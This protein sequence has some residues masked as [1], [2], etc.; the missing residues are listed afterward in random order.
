MEMRPQASGATLV[1]RRDELA[2]TVAMIDRAADGQAGALVISGDAGVGKSALVEHACAHAGPSAVRLAGACLPLSAMTVPFLALRSAVRAVE[3]VLDPPADVWGPADNPSNVPVAFDHWL[4]GLSRDRLVVLVIDD[5]QWADQSTLDVLMYL[6]AGPATRRLAVIITVRSGGSGETHPLQRWLADVRRFPR[7]EQMTLAPLDRVATSEQLTE[8]LGTSPHQTLVEEVFARTRGNAY[9]NRLLV[10]D[11]APDT[12]S[13][14]PDLPADLTS[15]VLRSWWM[16]PAPARDLTRILAAGGVPLTTNDLSS[17]AAHA[18]G[19]QPRLSVLVAIESGI[20]DEGP[21]G[22]LWFRHPMIAEVLEHHLTDDERARWHAAFAVH[23]ETQMKDHP[24]PSLDLLFAAADHHHRAGHVLDAYRWAL[25]AAALAGSS[26]GT[27]EELRLLQ[28]A[29]QLRRTHSFEAQ[30]SE[31]D[32][33]QRMVSAAANTG[34]HRAELHA[35]DQLLVSVDNSSEPLLAAQLLVRRAELRFLTGRDFLSEADVREAVRLSSA[36]DPASWQHACAAAALVRIAMWTDDSD[37]EPLADRALAIARG[38]DHP[39]ALSCALSAKASVDVVHGRHREGLRLASEAVTAAARAR[40]FHAYVAG[41]VWEHNSQASWSPRLRATHLRSRR[42]H[43][44]GLG[45]PHAYSAV[46]SAFEADAWL[47]IG[48]WQSC[49]ERLREALGSDPGAFVDVHARLTSARLAAWQGRVAEAQG[50]LARA[51][52]LFTEGSEFL[53]FS[54]DVSRAAVALAAGDPG[55]AVA[56][57]MAGAA[58]DVP[59]DKCEWLMALAARAL[60]DLS[61]MDRDAGRDPLDQLARLDDLTA[62]FPTVIRDVGE[63]EDLHIVALN[64]LY[65]AEIG[66]A[67]RDPHNGDQWLRARDS[68]HAATLA[69][70]EAYACWRAAESLLAH[71]RHRRT[72]AASV[73]RRGLVLAARLGAEPIADALAALAS[74]ARIEVAA[75]VEVPAVTLAGLP[76]LT[77]RESEILAHVVAGRTYRE[78]ARALVISEKTVSSH[79]SNLLRKTGTD[80]R[81]D[82]A[83]LATRAS[84]RRDP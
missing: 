35:V 24:S 28:R 68:C 15:A 49:R 11:L 23:V 51:D 84:A 44:V 33:L 62:R 12:R 46:L 9:L 56:A 2:A 80:N 52:E 21:D 78:I 70:E 16:L 42:T 13:L 29:I 50:H 66:R 17:V 40:D 39:L 6:L 67:R 59:P 53:A 32:L 38:A 74:S 60:A 69:W 73:L 83:R 37:M 71:D 81:V 41:V 45:A 65:V 72:P 7:V 14:P 1:G 47:T 75:V 55:S 27:A 30:E 54:F 18:I 77:T 64:D 20:L 79:I 26:G 57:A 61:E 10:K 8:I 3:S 43:M 19:P 31:R 63:Q 36:A 25:R 34:A 76:S 48:E 82:L 4:A 58:S 5:L 22:T